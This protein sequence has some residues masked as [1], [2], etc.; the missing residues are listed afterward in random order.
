MNYKLKEAEME[1]HVA[2][3]S[4]NMPNIEAVDINFAVFWY[5]Y[6]DLFCRKLYI[7]YLSTWYSMY[8]YLQS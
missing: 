1:I 3:W 5:I 7:I 6:S 4:C 8:Q 2:L